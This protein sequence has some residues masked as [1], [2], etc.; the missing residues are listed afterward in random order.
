MSLRTLE[1]FKKKQYYEI[2]GQDEPPDAE[3]EQI[4]KSAES[5]PQ[6]A[7]FYKSL[8]SGPPPIL[9]TRNMAVDGSVTPVRFNLDVPV[10]QIFL[11]TR[12]VFII[13]DSGSMDSGGWG[14][15]G[16]S[17]LPNGM[18]VG[19]TLDGVDIDFTPIP[20][21][22]HADLAGVAYDL[23]YHS[24]GSGDTFIVMRLTIAKTGTRIRLRGDRGDT[25]WMQ[26][27]DDLEYLVE[28]RCMCQGNIENVFLD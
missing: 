3:Y 20:W 14:N 16:G 5:G 23:T 15:N 11:V 10:G 12:F 22:S 9:E 25:F 2:T 21:T 19:V 26:V 13:R 17:P 4:Y 8:F 6:N 18:T 28:Q 27:N 1:G 7:P 24:W